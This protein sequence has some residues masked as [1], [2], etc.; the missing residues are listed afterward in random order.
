MAAFSSQRAFL[1]AFIVSFLVLTIQCSPEPIEH[2]YLKHQIRAL[3]YHTSTNVRTFRAIKP[4]KLRISWTKPSLNRTYTIVIDSITHNATHTSPGM[5]NLGL[6]L[7]K[8]RSRAASKQFGS[9]L[10]DAQPLCSH[11]ELSIDIAMKPRPPSNRERTHPQ[12]AFAQVQVLYMR[13]Q[14][15]TEVAAHKYPCNKDTIGTLQV[16]KGRGRGDILYPYSHD[17]V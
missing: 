6:L 3:N 12:A 8:F 16:D 5:S 4:L 17:S 7:L 10:L 14:F 13:R 11:T 2:V 15:C 1:Y 9:C